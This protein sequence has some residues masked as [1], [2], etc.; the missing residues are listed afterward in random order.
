M[1]KIKI[2]KNLTDAQMYQ[3]MREQKSFETEVY[4]DEEPVKKAAKP[5]KVTEQ[6]FRRGFLSP[7][8]E[9]RIGELL[10]EIKMEYY[11]DEIVDFS[12]EVRKEGRNI[13]LETAPKKHQKRI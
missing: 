5:A 2:P 3:G 9:Q 13:V 1:G 10:L 4:A 12:I 11:R 8:I 7:A 6:S